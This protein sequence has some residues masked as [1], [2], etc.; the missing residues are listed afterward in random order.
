[1]IGMGKR[2]MALLLA[3]GVGAAATF[4]LAAP[5]SAVTGRVLVSA[6]NTDTGEVGANAYCPNGTQV[7]GGGADVTTFG[8][9][10]IQSMIP[11]ALPTGQQGMYGLAIPV[12]TYNGPITIKVWAYCASGVSGQQIVYSDVLSTIGNPLASTSVTCPAGKKVIGAGGLAGKWYFTLDTIR[13]SSDL[14]TVSTEMY[15]QEG[16]PIYLEGSTDVAAYAICINPVPGQVVVSTSTAPSTVDKL[17]SVS[18]PAG[19]HLHSAGGGLTGA[20]GSA[21]LNAMIPSGDLVIVDGHTI[22]GPP[23]PSWILDAFAICAV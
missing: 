20:A 16:V 1:M 15:A 19:T 2:A 10:K 13:V 5:A 11:F 17:A 12:G 4:V 9:F 18:C 7:L 21:Y 23:D 22:P 14:S 8:S 6:T 3:A